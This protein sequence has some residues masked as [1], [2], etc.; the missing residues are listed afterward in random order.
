[1]VHIRPLMLRNTM[2]PSTALLVTSPSAAPS[3]V[4]A[5]SLVWHRL[6]AELEAGDVD[7]DARVDADGLLLGVAVWLALEQPVRAKASTAT[8]SPGRMSRTDPYTVIRYVP[9]ARDA[10]ASG[11]AYRLA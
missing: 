4:T 11:R 7:D 10:S 1:M 2:V 3:S 9:R 5:S 8:M 6:D